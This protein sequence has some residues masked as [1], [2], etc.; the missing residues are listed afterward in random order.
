MQYRKDHMEKEEIN[1]PQAMV[2]LSW[3]DSIIQQF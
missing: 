2:D 1:P 3:T